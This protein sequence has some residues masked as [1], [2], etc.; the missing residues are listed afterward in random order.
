MRVVAA[1]GAPSVNA[2]EIVKTVCGILGGKG[3]G[4]PALAQGAGTDASSWLDEALE[5]GRNEILEALHG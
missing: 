2:V 5:H 3:G 1:S 4:K